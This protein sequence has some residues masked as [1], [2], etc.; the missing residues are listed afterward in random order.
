MASYSVMEVSWSALMP[1][2]DYVV[3][4]RLNSR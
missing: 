3:A 1:T 4:G 2:G